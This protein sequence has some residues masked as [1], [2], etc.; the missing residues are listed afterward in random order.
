MSVMVEPCNVL[1]GFDDTGVND[2]AG[3]AVHVAVGLQ[4]VAWNLRDFSVVYR[5]AIWN[6]DYNSGADSN[7]AGNE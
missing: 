1:D 3:R 2:T 4:F 7:L 5:N 6:V